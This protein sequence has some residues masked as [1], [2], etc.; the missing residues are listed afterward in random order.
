MKQFDDVRVHRAFNEARAL[1][2]RASVLQ[3]I[4]TA[5]AAWLFRWSGDV[6]EMV[7]DDGSVAVTFGV[8]GVWAGVPE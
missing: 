8:D 4:A 6:V 3:H 5:A 1:K 7:D 2:T